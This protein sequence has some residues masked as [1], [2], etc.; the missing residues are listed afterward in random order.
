M[1]TSDGGVSPQAAFPL[2]DQEVQ[3]LVGICVKALTRHGTNAGKIVRKKVGSSPKFCQLL[4]ALG[5]ANSQV[6]VDDSNFHLTWGIAVL[7]D[8]IEGSCD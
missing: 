1:T 7:L 2:N 3:D 8:G 5:Q 4:I 6:T